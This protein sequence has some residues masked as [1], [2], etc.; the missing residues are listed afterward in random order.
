MSALSE[1]FARSGAH[2]IRSIDTR[3]KHRGRPTHA[4]FFPI[5]PPKVAVPSRL[6]QRLAA[7]KQ[8]WS[9]NQPIA[10]RDRQADI[11]SRSISNRSK[12][13]AQSSFE[14]FRRMSHQKRRRITFK[15]THVCVREVSM[16]VT[17]N[18]SRHYKA[19][20][21]INPPCIRKSFKGP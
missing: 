17:I 4:V 9:P 3:H 12:T 11:T 16:K 6:R 8:S 13:A 19:S 2:R 20:T 5:R 10:Q 1:L 21:A 7:K 15:I 18:Q 14:N